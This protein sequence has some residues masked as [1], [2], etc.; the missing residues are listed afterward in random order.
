VIL[1]ANGNLDTPMLFAGLL[2]MSLIGVVL[3]V[4]V[5]LAENLLLPWH[6]SRRGDAV[7]TTY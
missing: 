5:E 7:T 3:F 1:Q 2:V 4:L 6:A